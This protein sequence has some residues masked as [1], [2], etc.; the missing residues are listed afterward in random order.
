MSRS[1]SRVGM[2]WRPLSRSRSRPPPADAPGSALHSGPYADPLSSHLPPFDNPNRRFS[3][4]QST[5]R[6][7]SPYGGHGGL[8]PLPEHASEDVLRYAFPSLPSFDGAG[9][10]FH[11][12]LHGG[13]PSSLPAAYGL[14]LYPSSYDAHHHSHHHQAQGF[15]RHV[16][17]TSFDH[18]V[19]RES[20]LSTLR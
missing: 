5:A 17:K 12:H 19:S 1:R 16:R 13:H 10:D 6:P 3:D 14:G 8:P 18:T 15:P 11:P 4:P 20:M 2:D 7:S 9:P